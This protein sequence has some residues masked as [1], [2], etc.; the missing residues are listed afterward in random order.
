MEERIVIEERFSVAWKTARKRRNPEWGCD[1]AIIS[2][3]FFV[4]L[5]C[6]V[7]KKRSAWTKRTGVGFYRDVGR[8]PLGDFC[9]FSVGLWGWDW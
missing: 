4:V 9:D 7:L 6:V 3:F 1:V 8:R 5:C 2:G